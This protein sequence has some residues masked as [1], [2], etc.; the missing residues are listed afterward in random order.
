[1][2]NARGFSRQQNIDQFDKDA[3]RQGYYTYRGRQPS[4]ILATKRISLAIA[5]NYN[6]NGKRVLDLG[7]GDGIYTLEMIRLGAAWVHGID[8]STAA[9]SAAIQRS[10]SAGFEAKTKF[11]VADIYNLNSILKGLEFDCIML[12]GVLHH[13]PNPAAALTGIEGIAK[14]IVILEPNGMNPILKVLELVSP[15]HV[16]HGERSYTPMQLRQW[17]ARAGFQLKSSSLINLVPMFCPTWLARILRLIEPVIERLP[18][19]R[20]IACGQVLLIGKCWN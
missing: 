4:A 16:A 5:N 8:A 14:E 15:Y 10:T 12:W 13:L 17:L 7:C 9:I 6:F 2:K 20:N 19:L 1:M 11:E 18:G 3:Q